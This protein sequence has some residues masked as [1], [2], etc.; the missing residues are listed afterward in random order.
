MAPLAVKLEKYSSDE[1]MIK[2][3]IITAATA[4]ARQD[5]PRRLEML[6]NAELPPSER[7]V[8]FD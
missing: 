2:T 6:L 4:I 8:Y 7:I 3:L 5:N 1:A